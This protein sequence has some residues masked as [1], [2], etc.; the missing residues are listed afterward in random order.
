MAVRTTGDAPRTAALDASVL[1]NFLHLERL[2]LLADIA[3][4]DFVVAEQ[5]VIR[6]GLL[7]VDEADG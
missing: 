2:D 3:E 1:I 7:S 5:V 4:V 6:A